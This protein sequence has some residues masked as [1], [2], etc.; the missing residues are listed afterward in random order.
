MSVGPEGAE[1]R[2]RTLAS[3]LLAERFAKETTAKSPS[4]VATNEIQGKIRGVV[5]GIEDLDEIL[6]TERALLTHARRYYANSPAMVGSL[7]NAIA[8]L[9]I[10][11]DLARQVASPEEYRE[12]DRG[13]RRASSRVGG[14]PRDEARQFFVGHR[15]RLQDWGKA[16]LNDSEKRTLEVRV[17][18]LKA[19]EREYIRRQRSAL[20]PR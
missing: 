19:A 7:D 3:E 6:A 12:I 1:E 9:S 14:V 17:S 10:A 20:G 18:R 5:R 2:R 13:Y 4:V 16:E 11:A 15:R 8:E